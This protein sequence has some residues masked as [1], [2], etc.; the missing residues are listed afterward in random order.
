VVG[1]CG[2]ECRCNDFRY[3][4]SGPVHPSGGQ[5]AAA[6]ILQQSMKILKMKI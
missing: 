2:L 5:F 4:R 1:Q 6:G 3:G